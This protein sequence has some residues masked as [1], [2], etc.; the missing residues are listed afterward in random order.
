MKTI[1]GLFLAA[2]NFMSASLFGGPIDGTA[3]DVKVKQEGFFHWT[4]Q[5]DTLIFHGGR[6]V[7]AG[8]IAKGYEP[9]LYDSKAE[10]GATAFT[11]V[12]DGDGRDAVEWSG[13]VQGEKIAGSVVVRERGGRTRRFTFRGARKT[14]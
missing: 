10:D 9:V 4:S 6:A 5:R 12:L 3:W 11:L 7:I 14:G 13:R 2:V 8:E 1:A